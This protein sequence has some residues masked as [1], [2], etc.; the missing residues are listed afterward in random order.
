MS[1]IDAV[2][3][4]RS[5]PKVTGDAP[6][7]EQLLP[8]VEAAASL[9]DYGSLRPW[10]LIELRGDARDRLGA[11][12][13]KDAGVEGKDAEKMAA[14]P[15]R[16]SLLLAI[17][18][19]HKPSFKVSEWEQDVVAAGV[20]HLMSLLLHEAGWG[21]MWRS[22]KQVRTDSVRAMHE[23]EPNEELMGWLYVGGKHD[24]EKPD[25]KHKFDAEKVLSAL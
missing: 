23:L 21:V 11:A 19:V 6:T 1:L 9:A 25:K 2:A 20:G 18:A 14:K 7:H 3:G 15:L 12:L 13:A 5:H 22:G 10:R 8:L 16:A 24:R 4:R 17:V